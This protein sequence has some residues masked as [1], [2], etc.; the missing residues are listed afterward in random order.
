MLGI[1][2]AYSMEVV[3][4]EELKTGSMFSSEPKK[5]RGSS[6]K[7]PKKMVLILDRD[8]PTKRTVR[9]ADASNH[10]IYLANEEVQQ[11]D[12]PER[13]KVTVETVE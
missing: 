3:D 13:L 11:L 12:N 4:I 6:M 5:K 9:Y 7:Q 2:Y 10:N 8:K 1:C